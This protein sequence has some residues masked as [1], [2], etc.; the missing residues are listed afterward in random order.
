MDLPSYSTSLSLNDNVMDYLHDSILI[1][2]PTAIY[3]IAKGDYLAL[4]QD[5]TALHFMSGNC[6]CCNVGFNFDDAGIPYEFTL[7]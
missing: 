1:T 2:A 7:A 4:W 3:H 6:V 5:A